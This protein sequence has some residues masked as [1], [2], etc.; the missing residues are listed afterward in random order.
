MTVGIGMLRGVTVDL[1]VLASRADDTTVDTLP[2]TKRLK[3]TLCV[4]VLLLKFVFRLT[5]IA[6]LHHDTRSHVIMRSLQ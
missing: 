1:E 2:I 5:H 3:L 6:K 4:L